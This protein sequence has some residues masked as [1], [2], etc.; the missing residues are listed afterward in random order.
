[1]ACVFESKMR[2]LEVRT[3]TD[4]V[5]AQAFPIVQLT[6]PNLTLEEWTQFANDH[7]A[8]SRAAEGGILTVVDDRDYILG[9]LDYTIDGE[10]GAGRTLTV[11]N[12]MAVDFLD[13]SKKDV[14]GALISAMEKLAVERGCATIHTLV[15]EPGNSPQRQ[16]MLEL[17]ESSGHKPQRLNLCKS[18][19]PTG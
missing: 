16:W 4:P 3:L 12:L 10:L 1:M 13:T 5:I 17:L 15:S 7:M 9:L 19:T 2:R 18:L 8:S 14:A 6:V 11:K